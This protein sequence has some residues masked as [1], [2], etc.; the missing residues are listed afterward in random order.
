[1]RIDWEHLRPYLGFLLG[2]ALIALVIYRTRK[3]PHER[4]GERE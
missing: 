3:F 1:M 2:M 4:M